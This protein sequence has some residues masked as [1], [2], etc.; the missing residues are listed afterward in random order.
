MHTLVGFAPL[1]VAW[2]VLTSPNAAADSRLINGTPVDPNTWKEVV[3]IRSDGAGCTATVVGP[4]AIVTAAHC[5]KSGGTAAFTLDGKTY[6][7]VMT[8]SSLYPAQDHDVS[9]GLVTPEITGILPA[10]VGGSANKG[11]GITILGYGCITAGGGG[12]NDGIL[13][14]G[15][16]TIVEFSV[17]SDCWMRFPTTIATPPIGNSSS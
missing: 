9:L 14:I 11:D 15:D 1:L 4:R 16:S 8:R 2:C 13:R 12:G 6:S 10:S 7:A 3:R 5:A 17:F